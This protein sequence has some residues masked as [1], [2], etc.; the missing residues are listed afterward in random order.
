MNKISLIKCRGLATDKTK[1]PKINSPELIRKIKEFARKNNE[2]IDFITEI[3]VC[4]MTGRFIVAC[5]VFSN[6]DG[7]WTRRVLSSD[8]QTFYDYLTKDMDSVF[9]G[10]A[11]YDFRLLEDRVFYV[12]ENTNEQN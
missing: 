11:E 4:E 3:S 10:K 9:N 5:Q 7:T 6:E 1:S 12:F 8:Y 2:I